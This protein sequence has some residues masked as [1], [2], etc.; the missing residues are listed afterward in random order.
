MISRNQKRRSRSNRNSTV[1]ALTSPTARAARTAAAWM[2]RR[3][4]LRE[5]R[6]GRLLDE[7]LVATLEGAVALADRHDRAGRVTQELDLD[8]TGRPDLSLQID[9]AVSERGLGLRGPGGECGRQLRRGRDPA[10][11]PP[12]TPG[13][14]L[15]EE[16]IADPIGGDGDRLLRVGRVDVERLQGSRQDRDVGRGSGPAGGDLVAE[17]RDRPA[18]GSDE[19]D[20]PSSQAS[21]KDARS[22]RNP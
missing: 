3:S 16:R 20:P 2:A 14:R 12:A 19:H 15:D 13:G 18:R 1:A 4:S 17:H 21:A 7:L 6:R 10:H 8:V 11:P 5:E 22:D 9:R